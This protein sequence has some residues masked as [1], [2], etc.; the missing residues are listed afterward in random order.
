MAISN[1]TVL[2]LL[3]PILLLGLVLLM[4]SRR[5][6]TDVEANIPEEVMTATLDKVSYENSENQKKEELLHNFIWR[7]RRADDY[8][9][10]SI[11]SMPA[12]LQV[13]HFINE[14]EAEV[15]NGGFLQFFTNSSGRYVAETRAALTQIGAHY[16]VG[17]LDEALNLVLLHE[18]SP[19]KL[20]GRIEGYDLHEIF[21][22][23]EFYENDELISDMDAI[24]Q[25]FY[26]YEDNLMELKL[27]YFD[28]AP[29]EF[30]EK[31]ESR[32]RFE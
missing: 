18:E 4:S 11:A 9:D 21:H 17:L 23:S 16:T 15:N 12:R 10:E 20:R 24:D 6:Q 14:L 26:Q 25:K 2:L 22:S 1:T 3:A 5:K 13:V 30:W 19:D 7:I 8:G 29:D 28:N 32:Y 27:R 31:I